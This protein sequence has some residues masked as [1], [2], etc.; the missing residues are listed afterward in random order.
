M[1]PMTVKYL[2]ELLNDPKMELTDDMEIGLLIETGDDS[3]IFM[4]EEPGRE[5]IQKWDNGEPPTL[6]LV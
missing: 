4:A 6:V 1:M 2:R 3:N 5:Y